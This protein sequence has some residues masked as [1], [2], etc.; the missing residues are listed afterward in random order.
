MTSSS[1]VSPLAYSTQEREQ[2]TH[3]EVAETLGQIW[4]TLFNDPDMQCRPGD[5]FFMLGGSSLLA[6][7][8]IDRIKNAFHVELPLRVLLKC[9]AF[10]TLAAHVAE[11]RAA[12]RVAPNSAGDEEAEHGVL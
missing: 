9:S 10:D 7:G 4:Q 8:L 5:D 1:G 2:C 6:V 11:V 3:L 12:S